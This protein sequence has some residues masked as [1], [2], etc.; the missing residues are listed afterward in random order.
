MKSVEVPRETWPARLNEFTAAH[1]GWLVSLDIRSRE[2]A[3]RGAIE[4]LPLLGIS[5]DHADNDCS[6]AISVSRSR[7][8]HLTH[9]ID[10][11]AHVLVQRTEEGADAGIQIESADGVST[12]LRLRA[13]TL[14]E[15]VDHVLHG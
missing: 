9:V 5:I 3:V 2:M 7:F 8:D 6:I 1:E 14:T 11:V 4:G 12:V 10:H 15:R 13:P